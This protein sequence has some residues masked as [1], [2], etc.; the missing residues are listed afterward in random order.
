MWV[1]Q[2]WGLIRWSN[3]TKVRISTRESILVNFRVVHLCCSLKVGSSR[4]SFH[5]THSH[6]ESDEWYDFT[7]LYVDLADPLIRV[8][9]IFL[10]VFHNSTDP[11]VQPRASNP[12]VATFREVGSSPTMELKLPNISNCEHTQSIQPLAED[13]HSTVCTFLLLHTV[14]WVTDH[15]IEYS[16]VTNWNNSLLEIWPRCTN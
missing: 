7:L 11:S 2:S 3:A 14:G 6:A 8:S 5:I 4:V 12:R 13:L 1:E 10:V 9:K 16:C 15:T